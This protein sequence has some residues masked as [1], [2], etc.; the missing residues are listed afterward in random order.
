VNTGLLILRLA[1]GV[2]FL[3]HGIR[4]VRN[5]RKVI[6]WTEAIGFTASRIQWLFM[7]FGELAVGVGLGGGMLTA[8]SAAGAIGLLA[9]AFWTVHRHAGF[10]VSARPDEGYE[11]VAVLGA[12][13]LTLA[14]AGP[15]A[16]S[17]DEVWGT[18]IVGWAGA[19]VA[20][21]G[22]AAA[23]LQLAVFYRRQLS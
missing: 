3:A 20:A 18:S 6:V 13:C 5:R 12:M 10:F 4:H 22:V 9:V 15:G 7:A 16:W 21:S 19:G 23:A 11:Y 17:I 14:V 1:A 8:P 2:V